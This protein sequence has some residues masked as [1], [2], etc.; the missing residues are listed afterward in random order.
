MKNLRKAA[1]YACVALAL[2][3]FT[4]CTTDIEFADR[5]ELINRSD[6]S[7]FYKDTRMFS[8]NQPSN[9]QVDPNVFLD[10]KALTFN[11][12]FRLRIN[13]KYYTYPNRKVIEGSNDS[14]KKFQSHCWN[15]PHW[16]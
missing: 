8:L 4:N 10:S 11:L 12:S 5:N 3:T 9:S 6:Y 16:A 15:G 14:A 2:I 13:Q 7:F 1:Y